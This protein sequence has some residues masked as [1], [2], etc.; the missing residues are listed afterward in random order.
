MKEN[1]EPRSQAD[2]AKANF[3]AMGSEERAATDIAHMIN[4]NIQRLKDL[5]K[6]KNSGEGLTHPE[7]QEYIALKRKE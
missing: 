5:E 7:M 2:I 1:I 4:A 3:Q 6:K